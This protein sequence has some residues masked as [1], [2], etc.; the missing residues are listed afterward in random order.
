MSLLAPYR[1]HRAD[2]MHMSQSNAQDFVLAMAQAR[3]LAYMRAARGIVDAAIGQA[4][5]HSAKIIASWAAQMY[6]KKHAYQPTSQI[7]D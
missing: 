2:I 4:H 6:A 7:V 3:T 5:E 1:I